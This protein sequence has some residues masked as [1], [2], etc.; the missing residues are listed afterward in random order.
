MAPDDRVPAGDVL[1][2]SHDGHGNVIDAVKVVGVGS[3]P[4]AAPVRARDPL[5][6]RNDLMDAAISYG[7]ACTDQGFAA[8]VGSESRQVDAARVRTEAFRRVQALVGELTQL[9]A[10]AP[11]A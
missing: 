4:T 5:D 3:A 9:A 8:G 11:G 2:I 7:V 1:I 10:R 6:V